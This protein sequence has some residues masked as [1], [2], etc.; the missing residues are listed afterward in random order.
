MSAL[1]SNEFEDVEYEYG[2]RLK[3]KYS[4]GDGLKL[5]DKA[6]EFLDKSYAVLTDS[7]KIRTGR[8]SKSDVQIYNAF[9][10]GPSIFQGE[11]FKV[12]IPSG[13]TVLLIEKLIQKQ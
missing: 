5:S 11:K 3:L 8:F 4:E 7:A 13:K 9:V 10:S 6:E 12:S 1:D 2:R